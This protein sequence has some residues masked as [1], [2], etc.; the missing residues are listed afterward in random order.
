MA[1]ASRFWVFYIRKT[2]KNV[3]MVVAVLITS[4]Q[5]SEKPKIGPVTAHANKTAK[6]ST[7]A[8]G[9]PTISETLWENFRNNS[10]IIAIPVPMQNIH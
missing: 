3:T 8:Q 1:R 5:V 4:C 7:K 9:D 6:D 10:F 2:I